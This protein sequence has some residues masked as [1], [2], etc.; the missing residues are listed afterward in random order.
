LALCRFH[1]LTALDAFARGRFGEAEQAL[2]AALA[3][4]AELDERYELDRLSVA[5]CEMAQWSPTPVRQ[6]LGICRELTVRFSEDWTLASTVD[7]THARLLAMSGAIE[8]ARGLVDRARRR[9]SA[10]GS[11]LVAA[12]TEQAAGHVEASAREHLRAREHFIAAAGM[13]ER[14]GGREASLT[15][16]ACAARE[17]AR[18][19]RMAEAEALL[20]GLT[21]GSRDVRTVAVLLSTAM[22]RAAAHGDAAALEAEIDRLTAHCAGTDDPYGIGEAQFDAARCLAQVGLRRAAAHWGTEALRNFEAK[23]AELPARRCADWLATEG[24]A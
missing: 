24:V 2:R 17:L 1:Q 19:G 23:G 22:Y 15:L 10:L 6:A 18:A 11:G 3:T 8:E 9:A 16:R 14:A 5:L 21:T 13:I 20:N 12:A 7:L 4:V